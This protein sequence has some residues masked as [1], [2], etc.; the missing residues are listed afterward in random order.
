MK[1]LRW[2]FN[3]KGKSKVLWI[4]QYMVCVKKEYPRVDRWYLYIIKEDFRDERLKVRLR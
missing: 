4:G 3:G 2:S 1:H